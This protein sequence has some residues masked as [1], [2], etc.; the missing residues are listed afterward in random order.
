MPKRPIGCRNIPKLCRTPMLRVTMSAPQAIARIAARVQV[1][2]FWV[3]EVVF[4]AIGEVDAAGGQQ[5]VV[6]A[7]AVPG[8]VRRRRGAA[9]LPRAIRQRVDDEQRRLRELREP[10]FAARIVEAQL[11]DRIAEHVVGR[12][13]PIGKTI[14]QLSAHAFGLGALTRKETDS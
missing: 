13:R 8:D 5:R 7:Q 12:G 10:Q 3:R 6:F 14:E 4:M 11:A 1:V 2:P 9:V